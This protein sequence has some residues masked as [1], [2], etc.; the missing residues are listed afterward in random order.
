MDFESKSRRSVALAHKQL[1]GKAGTCVTIKLWREH[2]HA[3]HN[4]SLLRGPPP[5]TGNSSTTP[6]AASQE[7]PPQH[8]R[9]QHQHQQ[10]LSQAGNIFDRHPPPNT[11]R[12][13]KTLS[14]TLRPATA[15]GGPARVLRSSLSDLD[16]LLNADPTA[17][18]QLGSRTPP[19]RTQSQSLRGGHM[20]G[21]EPMRFNASGNQM[22][23]SSTPSSSRS[24][25]PSLRGRSRS[26]P[27][28]TQQQTP[29]HPLSPSL[30]RRSPKAKRQSPLAQR[31]AGATGRDV[32]STGT[33]ERVVGSPVLGSPHSHEMGLILREGRKG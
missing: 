6:S 32:E 8:H 29:P 15:A 5:K 20:A 19:R 3:P 33:N 16:S 7:C 13:P 9:D 31:G 1:S 22:Q 26:P 30:S 14:P 27:L 12:S 24:S 21:R 28:R 11:L 25:S 4:V 17:K 18:G 2:S 10:P 23:I